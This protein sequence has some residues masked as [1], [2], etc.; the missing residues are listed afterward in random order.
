MWKITDTSIREALADAHASVGLEFTDAEQEITNYVFASSFFLNL[1]T[2]GTSLCLP[3]TP[4]QIR[5]IKLMFREWIPLSIRIFARFTSDWKLWKAHPNVN[6]V[7]ASEALDSLTT[8]QQ[9]KFNMAI[10]RIYKENPQFF[11][12]MREADVDARQDWNR[13]G[14]RWDKK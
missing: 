7:R 1:R 3:S 13:M 10:Y 6:G 2:T 11:V 8:A 5:T 12:Q 4:K 14:I 9:Q